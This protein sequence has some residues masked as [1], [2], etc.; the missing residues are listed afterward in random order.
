MNI[1]LVYP[2]FLEQRV[3]QE[4]IRVPPIGLY[5]VGAML[6]DRGYD[7][8]IVNWHDKKDRL[9]EIEKALLAEAPDI[10]GIS[11]LHGNRWG[12]IDIA[13][14]AKSLFPQATVVFGG[15]GT[16]GLW[17]LLL[18]RIPEIDYAI[19]GEGESAFLD[20][21]QCLERKTFEEIPN[22]PGIAGR[23]DGI[24]AAT[25]P[26]RAIPELDQL[27]DPARYFTFQHVVSSRGCPGNCSFCG[28]PRYWG[29]R[30]HF[31]SVQYFVDQLERLYRKGVSFFYVSDDTFTLRSERVVAICREI[32]NRNLKIT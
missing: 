21:I 4:D 19:I 31:H 12:G 5:Y 6:A 13:R 3:H 2:Y 15:I 23:V 30:V 17:E 10:I 32:I 11:I 25:P 14:L 8:K 20:L 26:I 22:I 9:E 7:V 1:L 18:H 29:R 16:T 24:P 28:S 27:P